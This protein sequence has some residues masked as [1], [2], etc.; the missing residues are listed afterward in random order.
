MSPASLEIAAELR[1][2]RKK[3]KINYYMYQSRWEIFWGV[4]EDGVHNSCH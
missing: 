3:G 4:R 2:K 1:L